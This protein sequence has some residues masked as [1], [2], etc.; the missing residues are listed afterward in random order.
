MKQAVVAWTLALLLVAG[1]AAPGVSEEAGG[2]RGASGSVPG[3]ILPPKNVAVTVMKGAVMEVQPKKRIFVLNEKA[4]QWDPT[5][6]QF[7]NQRGL[8]LRGFEPQ[9]G[10]EVRVEAADTTSGYVALSVQVLSSR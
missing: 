4:I 3:S 2:D 7:L 8:P 9:T 6:T 10:S 5:L 1:A